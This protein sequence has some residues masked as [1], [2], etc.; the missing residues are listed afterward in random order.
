M[1]HCPDGERAR[2]LQEKEA[3]MRRYGIVVVA[4][5][6]V[7][8]LAVSAGAETI[9][10]K[11]SQWIAGNCAPCSSKSTAPAKMEQGKEMMPKKSCEMCTTTDAI[12]NKVPMCTVKGGRTMLGQ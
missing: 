1:A 4:V 6:F 5:V 3:G 12:G 7:L 9:F 11:A 8:S 2:I 10:N